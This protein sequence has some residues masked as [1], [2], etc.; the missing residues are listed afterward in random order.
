MLKPKSPTL[1]E[2]LLT[3]SIIEEE[4]VGEIKNAAKEK[5][6]AATRI[7][8]TATTHTLRHTTLTICDRSTT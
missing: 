7:L 5:P 1:N 4:Y 8:T 6:I 3:Y 2:L